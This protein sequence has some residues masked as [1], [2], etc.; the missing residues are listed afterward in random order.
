MKV[1][2]RL[3]RR[4]TKEKV[5]MKKQKIARGLSGK[6]P[7]EAEKTEIQILAAEYKVAAEKAKRD[8]AL[9]Q[10]KDAPGKG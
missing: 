4:A 5:I 9:Y 10:D 6:R 8:R 1:I 7:S 3:H 2:I